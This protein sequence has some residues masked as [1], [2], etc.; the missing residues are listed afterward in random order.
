MTT[1]SESG[2]ANAEQIAFW[3]D[4]GGP[5]WVREQALLDEQLDP[6]GR[7]A[8]D[9]SGVRAGEMV[10]DVG[11][12]CGS[13]S[14]E[15]ARRVGPRGKVTGVDISR[16]MLHLARE[17]AAR[18]SLAQTEFVAADAQSHRFRPGYDLVFSRFG[19]MFFDDPVAAFTNLHGTLK[20]SGRMAFLCWQ[21]LHRNPW[22]ALPMMAAMKHVTF[23]APA[24]PDAPGPFALAD[25]ARVQ[26]ILERAGFRDIA[27]GG[28]DAE[29]SIGGR[30]ELDE[31]VRFV[32]ELGPLAR[33]LAQQSAD[34]RAAVA[35]EVRLS[36]EPF[37]GPDGVKMA[38]AMWIV[39]AGA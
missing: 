28:L 19:V 23:D 38:G 31:T 6:V 1:E 25:A 17:R 22:M 7:Q 30:L 4:V 35:R 2:G 21:A 15:L 14:L 34:V 13:T 33:A 12:G 29:L 37:Q 24:S 8:I 11:C 10:I 18:E 5:R 20:P 26:S 36:L 16:P 32:L 3:N 39:T 27:T 9:A